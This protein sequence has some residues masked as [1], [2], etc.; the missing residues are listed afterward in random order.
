M[1][2][3]LVRRRNLRMPVVARLMRLVRRKIELVVLAELVRYVLVVVELQLL[4]RKQLIAGQQRFESGLM[5]DMEDMEDMVGIVGFVVVEE[6]R[7]LVE[8]V[9]PL[10]PLE[11]E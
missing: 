5:V 1:M 7:Q 8:N 6:P 3:E 4:Q 2:S 10:E 9:V 11:V